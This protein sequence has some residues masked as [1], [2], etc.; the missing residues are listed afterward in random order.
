MKKEQKAQKGQ[1][2]EMV[3]MRIKCKRELHTLLKIKAAKEQKTLMELITLILQN[4]V[5]E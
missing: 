5:K 1:E 3:Q 2:E 4:G